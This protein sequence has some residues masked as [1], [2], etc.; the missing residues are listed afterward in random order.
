VAGNPFEIEI[1]GE[2]YATRQK[3]AEYL[4]VSEAT[5]ACWVTFGRGPRMTKI[6]KRPLYGRGDVQ[7]WILSNRRG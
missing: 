6:G 2:H 5:L 3:L 1:L 7:D 4:Q